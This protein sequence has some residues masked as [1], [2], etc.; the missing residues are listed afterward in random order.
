M[1]DKNKLGIFVKKTG[2]G[3]EID[4]TRSDWVFC[5]LMLRLRVS[6]TLSLLSLDYFKPSGIFHKRKNSIFTKERIQ[7]HQDKRWNQVWLSIMITSWIQLF[8]KGKSRLNRCNYVKA[9]VSD[10]GKFRSAVFFN[11]PWGHS[12]IH[13]FGKQQWS[14]ETPKWL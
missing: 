3:G 10:Q 9:G 7:K 11:R 8:H 5:L 2:G 12:Q 13:W 14:E 4:Q 1:S 6:E